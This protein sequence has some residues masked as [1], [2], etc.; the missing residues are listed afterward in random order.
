MKK[1]VIIS[2]RYPVLSLILCIIFAIP[3]IYRLPQVKTV[4]NVDY[5]TI[6][7]DPD[8][9]FYQSFK[10]TFG[11]DEFFLVS[12]QKQNLF[13]KQNLEI[14]K[15]ITKK[16]EEIPEARR[17]RSL[18]N[19]DDIVGGEDFFE[20]RKFLEEIPD[21]N[22][23]LENLKKRALQNPLYVGN[24]ISKDGKVTAI[25]ILT[26]DKPEEES[27][28]KILISK[29]EHALKNYQNKIRKFYLAGWTTIDL[30]LSQYM[31]QDILVFI[32]VTY[33]MITLTLYLVFRNI[34]LTLIGIINISICLGTTMGLFPIIGI[35]INNVTTIVPPLV[36]ALAL[37][38]TVHIFSHLKKK[39][40]YIYPSSQDA[41]TNI[42]DRLITPCFLTSLT[43]GI[44]FLSLAVSKITPIREFA[45]VS[46]AG[47]VIEFIFSFFFLPPLLVLLP[48]EK[49][50]PEHQQS[51]GFSVFLKQLATFI[52]KY[53]KVIVPACSA[54]IIISCILA[55]R[56][57]VETNLVNYFKKTSPVRIAIDFVERHL[58]GVGTLDISLQS[59]QEDA[60]KNPVNLRVIENLQ[61]FVNSIDGIDKTMSFVDFIKQ[62]NKA[63]HNEN[64]K[65]FKIPETKQLVAQ[66]LL[67][68]DSDEIQD[69]INDT[70]DH[71]RIS[72]RTS[73]HS[74]TEQKMIIDKIRNFLKHFPNNSLKIRITGRALQQVN[75]IGALVKGQVYSLSLAAILIIVI[76][77]L[78][79]RS[80]SIGFLSIIPNIFPI[81]LNFGIM[82]IAGIPLNTATALIATVALGIAV[83]DTIH[84]LS[85]YREQRKQ[86]HS[87]AKAAENV[88]LYKGQAI[89]SS[90]LILCIGFGVLMLSRFMPTLYFG[91]LSTL[92]MITALIGDMLFLPALICLGKGTQS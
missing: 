30:N 90:S 39:L 25:A 6:Q 73:K 4:D 43:T 74:S 9:L 54:L 22:S 85:T 52:R 68:Y 82:G 62:M 67:L 28:R 91:F 24:L 2:A 19:V 83:D 38:D 86:G 27:Y 80:L 20:V 36:M 50:F 16:L 11:N 12:F 71:A 45:L 1:F 51:K 7:N 47:M 61:N 63:F 41:L 35:K 87:H 48:A 89:I 21:T 23:G 70:Y 81:A 26:Q 79:L 3:F 59:N 8:E 75:T 40:L 46:S 37:S 55:L 17:V 84:F 32:P 88:I 57:Q 65:Y 72:I 69:F 10:R 15:S 31:K 33:L 5:F 18:A 56:I 76:M 64:D 42:I 49:I 92:I 53:K 44:G 14:L 78:A 77:F 60:F 66:Y 58:S 34:W 29:C 13:T